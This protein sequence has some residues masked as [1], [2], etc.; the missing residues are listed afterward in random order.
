MRP[1]AL[2]VRE[3]QEVRT[4][5]P[6]GSTYVGNGQDGVVFTMGRSPARTPP[7]AVKLLLPSAAVCTEAR[8][9]LWRQRTRKLK[10]CVHIKSMS[11]RR[12][13]M[14]AVRGR[15]LHA[16]IEDKTVSI[17]TYMRTRI[18]IAV[19]EE[20]ARLQENGLGHRD[21]QFNNLILGP[22][23]NYDVTLVDPDKCVDTTVRGIPTCLVQTVCSSTP[24]FAGDIGPFDDTHGAVHLGLYIYLMRNVKMVVPVSQFL[25][26]ERGLCVGCLAPIP[27]PA[28]QCALCAPVLHVFNTQW[29][30][31]IMIQTVGTRCP[32]VKIQ[33]VF[34]AVEQRGFTKRAAYT[35]KMRLVKACWDAD[36]FPPVLANEFEEYW[37]DKFSMALRD[38]PIPMAEVLNR[39]FTLCITPDRLT[40]DSSGVRALPPYE[41]EERKMS[42]ARVLRF[43]TTIPEKINAGTAPVAACFYALSMVDESNN[44]GNNYFLGAVCMQAWMTIFEIVHPLMNKHWCKFWSQTDE[45]SYANYDLSP[46]AYTELH[47]LQQ[48]DWPVYKHPISVDL[49]K[50]VPDVFRRS[51]EYVGQGDAASTTYIVAVGRVLGLYATHSALGRMWRIL[52]TTR[53]NELYTHDLHI[54]C[55]STS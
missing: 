17:S 3:L 47:A 1:H 49:Q 13:E 42:K 55:R 32:G 41:N 2:R 22:A 28:R 6:P 4:R 19:W 23:P 51:M 40:P 44:A 33:R 48:C 26:G 35:L 20:V 14:D 34:R 21:L 27:P 50:A 7:T 15:S 29:A 25:S 45:L 5:A 46:P 36:T 37:R 38:P 24:S 18:M 54:V 52:S 31:P 16:L 30:L 10:N 39:T 43:F 11:R 53:V 8:W 12:C 9:K